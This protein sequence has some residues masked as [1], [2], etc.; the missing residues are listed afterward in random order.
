M[1]GEGSTHWRT[2][3]I[4]REMSTW[5][6]VVY[7]QYVLWVYTSIGGMYYNV[8]IW[9]RLHI[10]SNVLGHTE[11]YYELV[12]WFVVALQ[13][14]ETIHIPSK[15]Q[16][17]IYYITYNQELEGLA[18]QL[19]GYE[20]ERFI[21]GVWGDVSPQVYLYQPWVW[22]FQVNNQVQSINVFLIHKKTIQAENYF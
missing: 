21:Q 8:Y 22:Y 19:G 17:F 9:H 7:M 4:Y 2:W 10:C 20:M 14:F 6:V 16:F 18:P 3:F 12:H 5:V 1:V 15:V 11:R 13:L